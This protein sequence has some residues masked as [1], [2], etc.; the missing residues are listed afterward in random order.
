MKLKKNSHDTTYAGIE[1]RDYLL[2]DDVGRIT[3]SFC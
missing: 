1:F 3:G 2:Y